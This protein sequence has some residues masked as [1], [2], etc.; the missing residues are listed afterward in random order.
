MMEI[1]TECEQGSDLWFQYRLAS[2]GGTAINLIA[3]EGKGYKKTLYEFVGEHLTG[4]KAES[5]KFQ[6]ADRGHEFE[7]VAR[8]MYE[9]IRGV[10]VEQVALIKADNCRHVSPDGLV[11]K[12]GLIEIKTRIPSIFIEADKEG[13]FPI[14]DKRQIQWSL[15]ISERKWCDR[16][17]YCPEMLLA[18][19]KCILID[20]ITRDERMISELKDVSDKFIKAMLKLAGKYE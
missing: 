14:A 4:I 10:D 16:I 1:I 15:H 3:P 20:R 7:P 19:K 8:S 2:I 9:F 6:H 11:D 13:C 12:D 5:F 17:Q 18:N